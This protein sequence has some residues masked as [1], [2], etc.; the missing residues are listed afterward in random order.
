MDVLNH[1]LFLTVVIHVQMEWQGDEALNGINPVPT[2]I[3][4][5]VEY[6]WKAVTMFSMLIE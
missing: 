1:Q 5:L 3:A 4:W 2:P 6:Y